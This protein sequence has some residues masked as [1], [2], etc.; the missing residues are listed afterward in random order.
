ME[1]GVAIRWYGLST[2][3]AAAPLLV[4]MAITGP[5][6]IVPRRRIT[7][8]VATL[9]TLAAL[10]A[11]RRGIL[12]VVVLAPLI[13]IAVLRSG[14]NRSIGRT[15]PLWRMLTSFAVLMLVIVSWHQAQVRR[16]REVVID[17]FLL[18]L[19]GLDTASASADDELRLS[20]ASRLIEE[21]SSSPVLGH[22]L[23]SLVP[24]YARSVERP[25]SFELQYHQLLLDSGMLGILG[26]LIALYLAFTSLRRTMM[27]H[28]ARR[29]SLVSTSVGAVALLAAN[30]SNPYLQAVGHGWGVA[31]AAGAIIAVCGRRPRNEPTQ[32]RKT[33][34]SCE[35]RASDKE[36]EAAIPV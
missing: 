28:P 11:G 8:P 10:L 5:D 33:A 14:D 25:W 1:S 31:L 6:G 29:A 27:L 35:M 18:Y 17:S 16:I 36:L 4:A 22:G 23:G 34:A 2:L 30:A 21:W 20:Q 15:I 9:A 13:T 19:G 24:N 3:T 12:V 26:F 7:I 32:W